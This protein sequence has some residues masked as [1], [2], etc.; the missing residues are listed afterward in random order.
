MSEDSIETRFPPV[1]ALDKFARLELVG[2]SVSFRKALQLIDRFT[3]RNGPSTPQFF[4]RARP[5]RVKNSPR[6]PFTI[7]A[8]AVINRSSRSIA[9]LY[10]ITY[11]KA[12]C[13]DMSVA[14]LPTPSR[15][16]PASSRR[17]KVA[18]CFSTRSRR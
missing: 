3:K 10:L 18:R 6:A 16:A 12:N 14:P 7:L 8:H 1:P 13:S 15:Q 5:A 2:E 11:L 9:V 4:C 17:P